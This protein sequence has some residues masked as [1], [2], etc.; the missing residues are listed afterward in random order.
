MV[1]LDPAGSGPRVAVKDAID[2][3]GLPT[4]WGIP[5]LADAIAPCDAPTVERLRA[6]GAIPL[7]PPR[8]R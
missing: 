1:R 4:T 7:G 8:Y 5:A 6:A 2:V 3:A